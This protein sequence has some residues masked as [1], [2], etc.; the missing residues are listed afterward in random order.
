MAAAA[1]AAGGA[2]PSAA[3]AA[4]AAAEGSD[5]EYAATLGPY[6][7]ALLAGISANHTSL[8][9]AQA[10]STTPK[11]RARR[12]GRELASCESDLPVHAASSIFVVAD[13][14]RSMLW[15]ALIT[16]PPDTPYEGGAF[17]FDIYFPEH[18]PSIPPKVLIR[19]TGGGQVR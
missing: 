3:P 12:V 8:K 9:A 4:A 17:L 19:T 16:G 14:S 11:L 2:G 6:R 15:K 5:A 10:E 7:T 13:E 1:E 18:Y